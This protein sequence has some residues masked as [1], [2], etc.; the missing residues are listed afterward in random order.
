MKSGSMTNDLFSRIA[1]DPSFDLDESAMAAA[2]DPDRY[3]GLSAAQTERFIREQVDPILE[4]EKDLVSDQ[5]G[6]LR[7]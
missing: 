2:A 1:D 4:A 3:T 7:V 6:E 5:V